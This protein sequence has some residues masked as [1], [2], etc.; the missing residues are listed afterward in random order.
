ML[1]KVGRPQFS[2][3]IASNISKELVGIF[4]KRKTTRMFQKQ[5]VDRDIL[6]NAIAVAGTAPSGANKQPWSFVLIDDDETMNLIREKSEQEERKFYNETGP[7]K[8]L[9][10]LKHLHTNEDKSFITDACCLIPVFSK[11][12]SVDEEN[13]KSN[14][15]YV[16]ESVG[17]ATGMLISALHLCGLSV[18]TYTPSNRNFM[19]DLLGRPKS[20]KT[21]MVLVVGVASDELEVPVISK[22]SL[23]DIV[24]VYKGVEA[25][26][27][28]SN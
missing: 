18:L 22:K 12:F 11:N 7:E 14:N 26:E 23:S 4:R 2:N 6:L 28:K 3:S 9:N 1:E 5:K 16:K 19:V 10:D 24:S 21:F 25:R 27:P 15:Y 13:N 8:W 17:L 20:E